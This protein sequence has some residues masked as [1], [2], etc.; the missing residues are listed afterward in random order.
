MTDSPWTRL[1]ALGI[2][3]MHR[4]RIELQH[5]EVEQEIEKKIRYELVTGS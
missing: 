4:W 5:L 3:E 2:Q 1:E